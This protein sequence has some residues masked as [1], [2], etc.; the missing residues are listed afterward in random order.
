MTEEIAKRIPSPKKGEAKDE[1]VSRCIAFL[2]GEGKDQEQA[3]AIA[4]QQWRDRNKKK[5]TKT[6]YEFVKSIPMDMSFNEIRDKINSAANKTFGNAYVNDIYLDGTCI[7]EQFEDGVG[8]K[9]FRYDYTFN[10]DD[11]V[12]LTN[13]VEVEKDWEDVDKAVWPAKYVNNLKDECFAYIEPGGEKDEE[14]KT[15]PRSLRHFPY[16]D[17]SGKVD[18]PH[19]RNALARAPQ[20]PFGPKAMPKLKA[21]ARAVGVGDVKKSVEISIFKKDEDSRLIFG[22][23]LIPDVEDAQGDI[24]SEEEIAKT[25]RNFLVGYRQQTTSMGE[26]HKKEARGVVVVESYVAPVDFVVE[27]KD[28]TKGTWIVVSKI[29]SDKI[30]NLV[31]EGKYTGY[32][33]GGRGKRIPIKEDSE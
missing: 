19:L 29:N 18:L 24:I 4:Y 27:D 33:I 22:E 32:S 20:S 30:W 21:A 5:M 17:A 2:V 25:A 13:P 28:I 8:Y 10:A 9:Y 14:G 12:V 15:K 23:V 7:I 31:K 11:E 3:A 16:K 6:Q 26:M 1:Y